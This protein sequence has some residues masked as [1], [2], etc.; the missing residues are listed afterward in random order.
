MKSVSA[1]VKVAVLFLLMTGGGYAV[2]KNLSSDATGGQAIR[3]TRA[4]AT[5]LVCPS[6]RK[7]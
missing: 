4:F 7:L 2:W 1:G 6:V 3:C 5:H